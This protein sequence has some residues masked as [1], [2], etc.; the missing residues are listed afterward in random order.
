MLA[1]NVLNP[2]ARGGGGDTKPI[3]IDNRIMTTSTTT[4]VDASPP[5]PTTP[6]AEKK[7]RVYSTQ[8]QKKAN[9]ITRSLQLITTTIEDSAILG[10]VMLRGFDLLTMH[11]GLDLQASAQAAFD[12]R[13][14]IPATKAEAKKLRDDALEAAI[15]EFSGYRQTVQAAKTTFTESDR[16]TLGADGKMTRDVQKLVTNATAAYQTAQK[17]PYTELL[18]K[19]SY[20]VERLNKL[21]AALRTLV[22]YDNAFTGAKAIAKETTKARDEAFDALNDWISEFRTN[23]RLALKDQPVLIEKLGL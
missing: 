3:H 17:A 23:A 11:V 6:A 2:G 22:A 7:P 10:A 21:I 16:K 20:T 14:N 19:R 1:V 13:Q 8:S 5:A 4:V 18:S 12:A 9:A 15:E